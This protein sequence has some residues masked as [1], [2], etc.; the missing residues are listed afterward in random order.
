[1]KAP[2]RPPHAGPPRAAH[3]AGAPFPTGPRELARLYFELARLGARVEGE[4]SPWRFGQPGPEELL[5]MA[6][7]S[8]RR[9]PRLLW[10]LVELL[11]RHCD[12]FDPLKLRRALAAAPAPAAFGVA[13]EFARKVSDD[14][15][16]NDVADFVMK[17]IP[18]ARGEQFLVGLRSFGGELM[19]RDVEESL[20]EYKRWGFFGREEPIAKEL[21]SDARG[22]LGPA[23]RMN[24]LRR[25]AARDRT[26]TLSAYLDALK[27]R[28]SRRQASRDLAEAPFLARVGRTRGARYKLRA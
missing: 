27:G 8:A 3:G 26:V 10:A 16:L 28:A 11:A 21:G 19:R 24:V 9:D 1:M 22:S 17:R 25:L 13:F 5:V 7:Q 14:R 23:E 4:R 6:S 12:R 20:A 18:P 2:A 15:D